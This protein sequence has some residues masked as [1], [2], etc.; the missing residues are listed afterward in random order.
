[1]TAFPDNTAEEQGK[2]RKSVRRT[3]LGIIRWSVQEEKEGRR[4]RSRKSG[5]SS[6]LFPPPLCFLKKV[7]FD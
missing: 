4:R 1:L 3:Y 5:S 2:A 6:S 7:F